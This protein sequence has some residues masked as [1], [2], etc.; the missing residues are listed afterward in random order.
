MSFF[1][2]NSKK[3][4]TTRVIMPRDQQQLEAAPVDEEGPSIPAGMWEKCQCC[5]KIVYADDLQ[6]SF[7]VCPH[8]G[9]HFRLTA[10]QR[11]LA[12]VDEGCFKEFN[13]NVRG[14]DPLNFPG[15]KEKLRTSR[16]YTGLQDAI[17]TG[18]AKIQGHDCVLCA[19]DSNFMMGSMGAAVGE[20]MARAVEKAID[21]QIPLVAFTVSG[22]ARMQEG[23]VS[24]MQ[25]AK[26][27]A[28]ISKLDEA[29]LLYIV[30]L[31][32]PTTGGVTASF[33]MLGDI[34]L[35]EPNA[36]VGF[37]GRRVIMQTTRTSLPDYFQHAEFVQDKGFIDMIVPR[38]EMAETIG[39]ILAA[40][41][42]RPS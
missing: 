34:T 30:V 21:L 26:V 41:E 9:H 7:K 17:I 19:M 2:N 6:A 25:M 13:E 32:D 8:C 22:G 37:A 36:L 42:R 10:R 16:A 24:L 35:A 40:H 4:I 3:G 18:T 15:Y 28:T 12:T 39:K 33:A 31:T 29:G 38:S 5:Q 1:K 27:S 14:G 11:I 20:K 23:M